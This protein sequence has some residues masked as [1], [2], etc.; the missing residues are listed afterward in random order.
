MVRVM[1]RLLLANIWF[2][3]I[4]ISWIIY[5]IQEAYITGA[6][7]L[8]MIAAGDEGKRRQIQVTTAMHRDGIEVWFLFAVLGTFAAF[9]LAF[10][11][12]FQILYVPVFL[13]LYSFIA[14]GVSI[15]MIY[16]NESPRWQKSLILAWGISSFLIPFV[17][18]VYIV[19]ITLG[20]PIGAEGME[21]SFLAIFN[22]PSIA[23]GLLL[24]V[25]AL[26]SGAGFIEI[27]TEGDLGDKAFKLLRKYGV[28]VLVP[29]L[30]LIVFF[31]ANHKD[32]SM[33]GNGLYVDNNLFFILPAITVIFGLTATLS[34]YKDKRKLAFI[35]ALLT[36]VAY[37]ATLFAGAFPYPLPSLIN[38]DF[39][40]S[41]EMAMASQKTLF[42]MFLAVVVFVPIVIGYQVW[43]YIRFSDK[44]K[45]NDEEEK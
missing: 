5:L 30:A 13:L 18:G 32:T 39:S 21:G 19:T 10:A 38:H 43:K 28:Y 35:F 2:V 45:Y 44:I 25:I 41:I 33:F 37:I 27:T 24:V 17:I 9:P 36:L 31:G 15:E 29:L 22:L 34:V 6:S 1:S 11:N 23:G 42:I 40:V 12:T 20:L 4:A 26:V 3:F 7:M 14:R 16:K 8:N